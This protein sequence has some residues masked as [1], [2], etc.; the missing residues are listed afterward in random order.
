MNIFFILH[1]ILIC[2]VCTEITTAEDACLTQKETLKITP[3]RRVTTEKSNNIFC[4]GFNKIFSLISLIT[5][6]CIYL[7]IAIV[8]ESVRAIGLH[9]FSN[10]IWEDLL[11]FIFWL[12]FVILMCFA[13]PFRFFY[14][15]LKSINT[16]FT[17]SKN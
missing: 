8:V 16:L 5:A 12:Y 17:A 13:L 7:P 10:N 3:Q 1:Q 2:I 14:N 6:T 4:E 11:T 15:I 9:I